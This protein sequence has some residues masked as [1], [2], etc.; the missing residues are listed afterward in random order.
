MP[1]NGVLI[2]LYQEHVTNLVAAIKDIVRSKYDV[3]ITSVTNPLFYREFNN[4]MQ[5]INFTR[6]ELI[7]EPAVWFNRIIPKFSDYIDCDSTDRNIRAHSE[8]TLE[9]EMSFARHITYV[10]CSTIRLKGGRSFLN[11]AR[12]LNIQKGKTLLLYFV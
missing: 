10:G 4:K 3:L 9:Q 11:L 1:S 6:S 5:H 2:C 8:D 7:L 12:V